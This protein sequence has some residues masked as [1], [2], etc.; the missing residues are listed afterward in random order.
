P[1]SAAGKTVMTTEP[2]FIPNEAV[3]LHLG[4][5]AAFRVKMIDC[6]GYIVPGALGHIEDDKPRMVMTPWS[7]EPMPFETAA[8]IGTKKVINEH[9]TIG[10]LVT[11]DG[12]IGELPRESYVEAEARAV[13]ELKAQNKPFVIVLNS[14]VPSDEKS[15][16]LAVELEDKYGVP[17]A[18]VSCLDLDEQDIRKIL[19]LV[20]LE[21]PIK[22]LRFA[23]PRWVT[24]LEDTHPLKKNL[25]ADVS[26]RAENIYKVGEVRETFENLTE[27]DYHTSIELAHINLANG[28]ALLAVHI[29][30]DAFYRVL[31]DKTGFEIE[32]EE[33]LISILSDLA[34]MKR[35]YEKF[36]SAI[37]QVN[38]TGYGIVTPSVEDLT[39]EEPEIVKQPGGYGV[40]LR[41]SAPSIH[42]I[43][44]NIQT[45]H[46]IYK[47]KVDAKHRRMTRSYEAECRICS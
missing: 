36:E 22:E 15:V 26:A 21:F 34:D 11:T 27:D 45:E 20:L 3:E 38:E 13:S 6:V 41:A 42:M 10:V 8:E 47:M 25:L 28:Q 35:K 23:L 7:D 32:G 9:S 19:E 39:L 2:K 43:K 16:A 24:C 29:P 14:A 44:A 31:G 18:L 5:N 37:R 33:S 12:S 4:D 1:Q 30:E 46:F 40:R 17:V